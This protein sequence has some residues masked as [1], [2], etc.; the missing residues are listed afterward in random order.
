MISLKTPRLAAIEVDGIGGQQRLGVKV[1][2]V[3]REVSPRRPPRG[4]ARRCAS[5]TAV[6]SSPDPAAAS[7]VERLRTTVSIST[8]TGEVS[9]EAARSPEAGVSSTVVVTFEPGAESQTDAT[10]KTGV[11]SEAAVGV[12]S[13]VTTAAVFGMSAVSAPS[14]GVESVDAAVASEPGA[15]PD[16][17]EGSELFS[18]SLTPAPPELS[19]ALFAPGKRCFHGECAGSADPRHQ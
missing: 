18:W 2:V 13:A 6:S 8:V 16:C 1:V 4:C 7:G 17:G 3:A 10:S 14:E 5:R 11:T 19:L 12:A 15:A 9:S